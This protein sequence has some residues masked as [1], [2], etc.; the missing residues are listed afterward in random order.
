MPASFR[1]LDPVEVCFIY[2]PDYF[3]NLEKSRLSLPHSREERA[4]L[5]S[6]SLQRKPSRPGNKL[7]NLFFA[8]IPV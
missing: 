3:V 7:V 5:S 4:R 6:I 2:A 8:S 1:F